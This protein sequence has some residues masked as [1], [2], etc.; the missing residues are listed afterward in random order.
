M[1][2]LKMLHKLSKYWKDMPIVRPDEPEGGIE[3]L[4]SV[5]PPAPFTTELNVKF[6][7]DGSDGSDGSH[8]IDLQAVS[9]FLTKHNITTTGNTTL[10][11][12][13][14]LRKYQK[15]GGYNI[16]MLSSSDKI[17]GFIMSIVC[18]I[19]INPS[20][21]LAHSSKIM[22]G[23]T[24][25]LCVAKPLRNMGL[26]M[27]LM[28]ELIASGYKDNVYC[29][30]GTAT[31]KISG[32]AV[33]IT[34]WYRPI[35]LA[36]CKESGFAYKSYIKPTDRG[37]SRD[38]LAYRVSN[39]ND[40][41]NI[42]KLDPSQDV[43]E[44][45]D[46]YLS[47]VNN[48]KVSF[49]PDYTHWVKWLSTFNT[50]VVSD[51]DNK[52]GVFSYTTI[53]ANIAETGETVSMAFP[54]LFVS[55]TDSSGDNILMKAMLSVVKADG[56]PLIYIYQCGSLTSELLSQHNA[57]ETSAKIYLNWYN[58]SVRVTPEDVYLPLF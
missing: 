24:S 18:P 38:E 42:I 31:M 30:Y 43:S 5:N 49:Y 26:A 44:H 45:L 11:P 15:F 51:G 14:D 40:R 57:M 12:A 22:C 34:A 25:H 17:I 10:C 4:I 56:F 20:E 8:N 58:H 7:S 46:Y 50:Y 27:G 1:V 13:E 28:K 9:N 33:K 53:H 48:K 29:S 47:I 35:D 41:Y 32:N 36:K 16:V 39:L 52:L 54:L 55:G 3:S 2:T 37:T 19:K 21:K 6:V 23:C